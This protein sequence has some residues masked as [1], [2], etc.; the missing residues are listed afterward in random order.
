MQQCEYYDRGC[1][2]KQYFNCQ[3]YRHID[4][5]GTAVRDA[6]LRKSAQ[7]K[8]VREEDSPPTRRT[9]MRGV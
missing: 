4:S 6:V 5:Q 8:V 1:K 9:Q 3:Q 7:R 2:L